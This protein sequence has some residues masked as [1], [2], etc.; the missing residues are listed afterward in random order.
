M[1]LLSEISRLLPLHMN[2]MRL[3][4]IGTGQFA[5]DVVCINVQR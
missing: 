5:K 2:C 4:P 1:T 3:L